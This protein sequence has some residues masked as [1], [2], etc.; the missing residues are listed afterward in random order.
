MAGPTEYEAWTTRAQRGQHHP[1]HETLKIL[2]GEIQQATPQNQRDVSN[3]LITPRSK[4]QLVRTAV[5]NDH[6]QVEPT[7]VLRA[8]QGAQLCP[9]Q[10]LGKIS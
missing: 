9:D 6:D 3:L 1:T 2:A 8:A 10:E 7:R 4:S 5:A